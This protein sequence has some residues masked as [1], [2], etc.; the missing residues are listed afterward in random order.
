M[1]KENLEQLF[2]KGVVI[3]AASVKDVEVKNYVKTGSLTLDIALAGKGIP[4]DGRCTC[5]L[6][7]E[8]SSKTTLAQ[9]IIAE[10]QKL[11][12]RC[13]FL[14]VENTFDL[15]YAE[16][17]GVNLEMLDIIDRESMLKSFGIKDRNIISG[18]EWIT[19]LC[20]ILES[21]LYGTVV[22]DSVAALIPISEITGGMNQVQIGRIGSMMAK[23]YRQINASLT[24]SNSAFV[25]LNQ[26]RMSPG[27][28]NPLVEPA[29]E[30]MKYLQSVKIEISKSLDK[31][32]DGV[33]GIFVKGKITKSK[34]CEPYKTF[35]YYVEFGKGI[36]RDKEIFD[37][38]VLKGIIVKGGAWFTLPEMEQK[39]QGEDK[40]IA[41]LNDNPLFK[42][43]IENLIRA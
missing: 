34:V 5:I 2:G 29:G 15:K 17:T 6:G 8:S 1:N 27:Q 37:I 25:Y 39:L 40:V 30:A 42:D 19:L 11:G 20:K 10:D 41:F 22:L 32:V 9:H 21:N 33:H 12:N 43:K 13:I 3:N 18:E 38:A 7:K 28:Y 23:A 16:S 31:D 36:C 14:D 26:Y 35:E 4:K 24:A